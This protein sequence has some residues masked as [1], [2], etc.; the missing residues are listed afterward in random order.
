M[1]YREHIRRIA[2]QCCNFQ[3]LQ[4][5]NCKIDVQLIRRVDLVQVQSWSQQILMYDRRMMQAEE[6]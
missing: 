4:M 1:I 5:M 3:D 2:E 6:F